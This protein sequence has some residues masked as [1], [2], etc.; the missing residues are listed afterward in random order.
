MIELII[1][2][3]MNSL[4]PYHIL[5]MVFGI[6]AGIVVGTLPGLT[7]TMAV[8]LLVPVT[9][10]MEPASG[11]VMLGA[12]WCG[13]IY[14]GANAAILL[15]IPG[16]PSSIATTFDGY[17]MTKNGAADKALLA[18]LIS[19]VIGGIVGVVILLTLFAPLA[20][21]SLKFGKPEYFWLCIFGLTTISAMSTGNVLKGLLGGLLGLLIGTIGLDPVAGIPRFTFGYRPLIQ[22]IQ[23]VPALI[24]FFAFSQMLT[25]MERNE[26]YIAKY[27]QT[28]NLFKSLVSE[29]LQKGRSIIIRSSILGAFIGML[30]GAGGPVAS[31]IAY[32]EAK[33]WDKNPEKY[34]KGALEG[35]MASE[36]SN[37]AVIGGSLIPMMALGIPGCPAAAVVMGGLLAHGIIPGSKLLTQS[38]DVAYTF[39]TSLIIANLIMLPVG[40]FMIKLVANILNVPLYFV[41]PIIL[42]LSSIGAYALRNSMFD[43]FVMVIFGVIAY[44][45]SKVGIDPGPLA[46]GLVLGPIAEDALG[47]SLVIAHAKGSILQIMFLRPVSFILIILSI[48]SVFTPLILSH[49]K[50]N[51][52]LEVKKNDSTVC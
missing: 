40:Y 50:K 18:S 41:A 9:F 20:Q 32:N 17:Q 24:G 21:V 28:P 8:A 14:G 45:L 35:I 10:V 43:V 11:L 22:G 47:V 51:I 13:A 44:I 6:A 15:N 31:L 19:S 52:G 29:M 25:L 42:V 46:L 33:R 34:G 2:G 48:L 39:I 3:F 5:L 1:S 23:L 30:P 7:A 49:I 4:S 12:V 27:K 16:T 37:N 36:S 38:G 26:K